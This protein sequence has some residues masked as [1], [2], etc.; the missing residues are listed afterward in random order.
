MDYIELNPI[1]EVESSDSDTP[2]GFRLDMHLSLEDL[3][4]PP[5]TPLSAFLR[6]ESVKSR[7]EF[8]R[9]DSQLKSK[10]P[11]IDTF[12]NIRGF[13]LEHSKTVSDSPIRKAATLLRS[14]LSDRIES[15]ESEKYLQSHIKPFDDEVKSI[16]SETT[17]RF[18]S[19]SA[20][21]RTKTFNAVNNA[22][23]LKSLIGSK[24]L[25]PEM[26]LI[27]AIGS[28]YE[29]D[30]QSKKKDAFLIEIAVEYLESMEMK[31]NQKRI[32]KSDYISDYN[33]LEEYQM[34][35][36][37]ESLVIEE[38]IK[39]CTRAHAENRAN[40]ENRLKNV[41]Y[42]IYQAMT[43]QEKV[44]NLYDE[45]DAK[46]EEIQAG[47]L[48]L[49]ESWMMNIEDLQTKLWKIAEEREEFE[50]ET[51]RLNS[52][53]EQ[54]SKEKFKS[55]TLKKKIQLCTESLCEV[56]SYI[57]GNKSKQNFTDDFTGLLSSVKSGI[58]DAMAAEM[59]FKEHA[60]TDPRSII[61]Y[62]RASEFAFR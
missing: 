16:N 55:K 6:Q 21:K 35:L 12:P 61:P 23:D 44:N 51:L 1:A 31:C 27:V 28:I 20:T 41:H 17:D 43:A 54:I 38:E 42:K 58:I 7:Y 32:N 33:K 36:R 5:E 48:A 53:F 10:Q 47:L 19:R 18:L 49:E 50:K 62:Y 34:T 60:Q 30:F 22:D 4:E 11:S 13:E 14:N 46:Y 57:N 52:L 15:V 56:T 25:S 29:F 37:N 45:T 24:T 3:P 26:M 9:Q 39:E 8:S 40:L 2:E 59:E